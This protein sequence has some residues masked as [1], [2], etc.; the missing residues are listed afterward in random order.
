[1]KTVA[2]LG[3]FDTKGKE[4]GFV[5]DRVREHGVEVILVDVGIYEPVGIR[6]T[7]SRQEVASAAHSEVA[8]LAHGGDSGRAVAKM[9]VGATEILRALQSQQKIDGVFALGGGGGASLASQAMRELPVGVPKLILTT[10]A[11]GDTKP[12]IGSS[13]IILMQA[14]VDPVGLNRVTRNMFSN[15]AAAIAAMAQVVVKPAE[16]DRP[17]IA[18]SMF[19]VTTPCVD[20]ARARMEEAGFEVLVFHATGIG[21]GSMEKLIRDRMFAGVLDITLTELADEL[22]GGI[23]SAGPDR[24]EAASDCQ[25]PQVVSLGALDMV[26]FGPPNSVPERFNDRVFYQHNSIVTL[27]RTTAAECAQLGKNVATKLNRAKS[28]VTLFIPTAGISMISSS[29]QPFYDPEADDV[30]ITTIKENIGPH[31]EVIE[32]PTSINEPAFA[33]AMADRLIKY[34]SN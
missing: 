22:V 31:V 11:A 21:G 29:G 26:N 7:I 19:G 1:M 28:D 17:L 23:L 13:D 10:L 15:A 25:I 12:I 27:M 6:P 5:A 18:A 3:T 30:L 34:C 20:F 24:L 33:H 9:A 8:A 32:I 16:L 2:L 4:Y 14:V